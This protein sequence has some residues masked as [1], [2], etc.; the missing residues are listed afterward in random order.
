MAPPNK[1]V[2]YAATGVP[3]LL[4]GG[5]ALSSLIASLIT[6]SYDGKLDQAKR[7]EA[8]P[9]IELAAAAQANAK[10]AFFFEAGRHQSDAVV[11]LL[12]M[13]P[14]ERAATGLHIERLLQESLKTAPAAPYNWNRLAWLRL[15]KG[16]RPGAYKAWQMSVLTGRYVP[17]LMEARLSVA[18]AMVPITDP[19]ITNLVI[20]QIRLAAAA[21]VTRLARVAYDTNSAPIIRGVL[22]RDTTMLPDFNRAYRGIL[23]QERHRK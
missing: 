3:A 21:N 13:P 4:L 10:A 14:K 5:L 11:A 7:G 17:G 22:W 1:A 8:V 6:L 12:A 23:W 9:P 2:L 19:A 18:L 16:D 15:S 20:D